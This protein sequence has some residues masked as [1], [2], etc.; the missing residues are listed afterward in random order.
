[1]NEI[2]PTGLERNIRGQVVEYD[3]EGEFFEF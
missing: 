2:P 1:M 3:G